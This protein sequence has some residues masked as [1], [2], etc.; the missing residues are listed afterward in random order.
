VSQVPTPEITEVVDP[1]VTSRSSTSPGRPIGSAEWSSATKSRF[2]RSSTAWTP[3]CASCRPR[4]QFRRNRERVNATPNERTCS[5]NGTRV[6]RRVLGQR[7]VRH[8]FR[9]TRADH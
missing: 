4:P 9:T 6:R 5:S 1:V 2:R 8:A 3:G 7:R